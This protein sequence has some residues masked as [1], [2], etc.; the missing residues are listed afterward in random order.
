MTE[1]RFYGPSTWCPNP[2]YWHSYDVDATEYEVTELVA[3]FIRATQP[4]VVVETG[5]YTGQ[6]SEAIGRALVTNG[7]GHLW[8]VEVDMERAVEAKRRC[9]DLPVTVVIGDSQ[10]WDAPDNIDFAWIDGSGY[11]VGEIEH[12]LGK[13]SPGAIIG[14]HDAGPRFSFMIQ[15]KRLTDTGVLKSIVLRTPRGVMFAMVHA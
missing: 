12:L 4:E 5:S 9:L 6:T 2:Q 11:R 10:D 7:H 8:T 14:M 1:D 13:F 15:V 3:A